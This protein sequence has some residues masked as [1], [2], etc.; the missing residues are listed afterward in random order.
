[1]FRTL[2]QFELSDLLTNL[3]QNSHKAITPEKCGLPVPSTFVAVDLLCPS[4][5]GKAGTNW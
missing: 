5:P 1:M 4:I 2:V 3:I